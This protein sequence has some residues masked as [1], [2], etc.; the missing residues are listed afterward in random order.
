[1]SR[2]NRSLMCDDRAVEERFVR[3]SGPGGQ[4]RNKEATAVELRVDTRRS[5]LPADVRER[6]V[7]LAG[8]NVIGDG[9]LLLVGRGSRSQER[10][11]A[12]VRARLASLLSRATEV[13]IARKPTK[14]RK[15]VREIRLAS[16]RAR[17]ALKQT[18]GRA[19]QA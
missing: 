14:P 6:L 18:R 1:M 2:V 15:R 5:S 12:D 13:P 9:V 3:A 4:N 16:K 7:A 10:N 19:R 8:K 11:R 17:S